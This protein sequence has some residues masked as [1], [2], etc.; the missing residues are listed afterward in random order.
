MPSSPL[1][2]LS[3]A[4]LNMH[5]IRFCSVEKLCPSLCFSFADLSMKSHSSFHRPARPQSEKSTDWLRE[6]WGQRRRSPSRPGSCDRLRQSPAWQSSQT[7]GPWRRC[8]D[9]RRSRSDISRKKTKKKQWCKREIM[10][11]AAHS[12][13]LTCVSIWLSLCLMQRDMYLLK[14]LLS[15]IKMPSAYQWVTLLLFMI[16]LTVQSQQMHLDLQRT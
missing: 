15:Q 14:G 13:S 10:F 16:T 4:D 9:P 2:F 7:S 3:A 6:L 12:L 1:S 11:L 5:P 8:R